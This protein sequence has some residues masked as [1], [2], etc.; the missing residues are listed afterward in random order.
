[1]SGSD[2]SQKAYW[3][4]G[5]T[6]AWICTR[7]LD[8]VAQL[9]GDDT[10]AG[11]YVALSMNAAR[12]DGAS[13]LLSVTGAAA[14]LVAKCEA[15]RLIASGLQWCRAEPG[16]YGIRTGYRERRDIP[17][18][19]WCQPGAS[20]QERRSKIGLWLSPKSDADHWSALLFDRQIVQ[21]LWPASLGSA[22]AAAETRARSWL[23]AEV[24]QGP[25]KG[26]KQFYRAEIERLFGVTARGFMRVW[27]AA[28]KVHGAEAWTKSGPR[29]KSRTGNSSQ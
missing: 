21:A 29:S 16:V 27:D 9:R 4:T 18:I 14:E 8:V 22:T 6:L 20:L 17:T 3:Q 2:K 10:L 12:D 23:A 7:S 15:G 11:V 19:E 25:P 1:M 5:E 13:E 24:A 28:T 26:T